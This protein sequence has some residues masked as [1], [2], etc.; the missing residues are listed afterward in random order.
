[1]AKW[2]FNV[3]FEEG[4]EVA[5][6]RLDVVERLSNRIL[7]ATFSALPL[8]ARARRQAP[9]PLPPDMDVVTHASTCNCHSCH[10][11]RVQEYA[12]SLSSRLAAAF[13]EE[14]PLSSETQKTAEECIQKMQD[15]LRRLGVSDEPEPG[16]FHGE[17][18]IPPGSDIKGD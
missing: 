12:E 2:S 6:K 4:D 13:G 5:A 8:L 14:G 18:E 15:T 1:M 10:P 3:T 9:A 11:D 7:D 17:E 16:T